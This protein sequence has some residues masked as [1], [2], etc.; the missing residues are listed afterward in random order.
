MRAMFG[1]CCAGTF[2]QGWGSI[3]EKQLREDIDA[4]R[5]SAGFAVAS[6]TR[7]Q[8]DH[9]KPL[10]EKYGFECVMPEASNPVHANESW[11]TLWVLRFR[12]ENGKALVPPMRDIKE[13]PVKSEIAP[14]PWPGYREG[15]PRAAPPIPNA[16]F[17]PATLP[18]PGFRGKIPPKRPT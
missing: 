3:S 2:I 4:S 12:D 17:N 15:F 14:E 1:N 7:S 16:Y 13:G 8:M 5:L 9:A 18:P 11:V 10:L 6:V